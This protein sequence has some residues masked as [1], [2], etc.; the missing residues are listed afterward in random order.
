MVQQKE[1]FDL[2]CSK[3]NAAKY[4][5]ILG[6]KI[7]KQK[8]EK[9]IKYR[10]A[11]LMR[12]GA[13]N[14]H[15][16][17][18]KWKEE[19]EDIVEIAPKHSNSG[20]ETEDITNSCATFSQ[21]GFQKY[22]LDFRNYIHNFNAVIVS[23][24]K[25]LVEKRFQ[26]EQKITSRL[27]ELNI[28]QEII[29]HY[30]RFEEL[31]AKD[32]I[33][34][35][36]YTER[37]KKLITLGSK[38]DHHPIFLYGSNITGKTSLITKFGLIAT[39]MIEPKSYYLIV[40]YTD[41]S[42]QCS[43]FEG[44]LSS[45]CEQL[46]LLQNLS[47]SNEIENKDI[48]Q[49][50]DYFFKMC[51]DFTK[52]QTKHLVI[53]IDGLADV[54]VERLYLSKSSDTNTQINWLFGQLLPPKVHLIVSIK[55][56][57]AQMVRA[58]SFDTSIKSK[59][60]QSNP[61]AQTNTHAAIASASTL[62]ANL[63]PSSA[64][65]PLFLY[66][67]NERLS[68]E[69]ENYLFELPIPFRKVEPNE[70]I[71]YFKNDGRSIGDELAM[72]IVQNFHGSRTNELSSDIQPQNE[73]NQPNYLYLIYMINEIIN[74]NRTNSSF[75]LDVVSEKFPKDFE[76]YIHFKLAFNNNVIDVT[77][78]ADTVRPGLGQSPALENRGYGQGVPGQ[79]HSFCLNH[80]KVNQQASAPFNCRRVWLCY[81]LSIYSG[82]LY[83]HLFEV[84][85]IIFRTRQLIQLCM[86]HHINFSIMLMHLNHL[87]CVNK[88]KTYGMLVSDK[89]VFSKYLVP[90]LSKLIHTIEK[91]FNLKMISC[92]CNYITAAH[93]GITEMELIDLLS[94]N[95]E[96]IVR[97]EIF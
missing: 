58:E 82:V 21:L 83:P 75:N 78:I 49:L 84:L 37:F 26:A 40:R 11:V 56:Q 57:T 66:N 32:L 7:E 68:N 9:Q 69:T 45:M 51:K 18:V 5:D 81:H 92:I 61:L 54:N 10:E 41:L 35:P 88:T 91:R 96:I 77:F 43:T 60:Y 12:L 16:F 73:N 94:C 38:S 74:V 85:H 53:M 4:A 20:S 76:A 48:S 23:K 44:L 55:R 1:E 28:L 13:E 72:A 64:A 19:I 46:N 14:K 8:D 80:R 39:N 87:N 63:G 70:L 15:E 22:D 3:K 47:C 27:C 34:Y 31:C 86:L 95:N 2:D 50:I 29:R 89:S 30:S 93:N 52:S 67:F 33:D 17:T 71:F 25:A 79:Y 59:S 6:S 65:V 24:V 42:N 90:F 97:Q 36:E 62:S